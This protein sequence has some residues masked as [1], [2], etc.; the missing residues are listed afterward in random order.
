M[1]SVVRDPSGAP[2]ALVLKAARFCPTGAIR[3]ADAAGRLLFPRRMLRDRII[4][5]PT[6]RKRVSTRDLA[7]FGRDGRRSS[8]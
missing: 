7:E 3:V 4:S 8:R 5:A 1:Q 2:E 6:P